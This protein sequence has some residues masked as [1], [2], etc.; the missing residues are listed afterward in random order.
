M[1]VLGEEAISS[2]FIN[3]SLHT[4][5]N[6]PYAI[7]APGGGMKHGPLTRV[8]DESAYFLYIP[9]VRASQFQELPLARPRERIKNEP[10]GILEFATWETRAS[11]CILN[12]LVWDSI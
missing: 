3:N 8:L 2:H 1:C 7:L 9:C 10:V 5:I 11:P 12:V 6:I 4:F